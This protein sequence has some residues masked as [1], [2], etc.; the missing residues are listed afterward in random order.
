[1]LFLR[2]INKIPVEFSH[3]GSGEEPDKKMN[4]PDASIRGIKVVTL[5]QEVKKVFVGGSVYSL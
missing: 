3:T 1:V 5:I 4:Y 2:K